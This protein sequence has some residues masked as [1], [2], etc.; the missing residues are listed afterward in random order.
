MSRFKLSVNVD[1][2]ATVRQQ[3]KGTYPDP[4]EGAKICEDMGA[5]GIIV[6]L[7]EDRRHI[8]DK[9]VINLKNSVKG[10]FTL[11]MAMSDDII[12]IAKKIKPHQIT[13]VPEKRE[14]LTTE[15]GLDVQGNFDKIKNVI[16]E[17]H[18]IGVQT[19]LFIE[20][21]VKVIELSKNAGSDYIEIHTGSYCD[22]K[23]E[24]LR[25]KEFE[26]ILNAAEFACEAGIKINAGHGLDINNLKPILEMKGL[27]ELHIGYSI[28][29]RSIFLG[30][31][32]AVKE[33]LDMI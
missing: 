26:T 16:Q 17:F 9:D 30:L 14:E 31:S 33:I 20:P 4:V 6:H 28:I 13:L 12:S 15:G 5:H 1:H 21:D 22:A 11:E 18:D 19:S 2:I 29:A 7:R 10:K 27:D 32:D 23:N 8:Q 25:N 3:R 24:D